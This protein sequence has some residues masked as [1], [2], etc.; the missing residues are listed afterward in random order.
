MFKIIVEHIDYIVA[1]FLL[2][3]WIIGEIGGIMY[4]RECRKEEPEYG[5]KE[6]LRHK[7]SAGY[8]SSVHDTARPE[9]K[10]KKLPM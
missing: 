10:R 8:K 6:V 7:K 2:I 5:K 9:S 1:F 3:M 4:I